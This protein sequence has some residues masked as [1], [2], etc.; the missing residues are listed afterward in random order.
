VLR[1]TL[2]IRKRRDTAH[3]GRCFKALWNNVW[4][5]SL[6]DIETLDDFVNLARVVSL[7]SLAGVRK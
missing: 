1:T 6:A 3:W 2:N 4:V 5:R 7:G